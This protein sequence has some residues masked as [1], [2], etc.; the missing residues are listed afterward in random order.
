V[1][2]EKYRNGVKKLNE[3]NLGDIPHT[4][5]NSVRF[6][7]S[8]LEKN[9]SLVLG[10]AIYDLSAGTGYIANEFYEAGGVVKAFDLFPEQNNYPQIKCEKINLQENFPIADEQADFV[11]LSETFEHLPNQFH[12]FKEAARILKPSGILILTTPNPS[13]LRGR[14]SQFLME[15]EHYSYP[16]ADETNAYANWPGTTNKYFAKIFM[17]G[18]LRI[19]L[20]AALNG[21]AIKEIHKTPYSSTSILLLVFYP[22]I[23]FFSRKNLKWQ[24]K[25]SPE[26][27][28]IYRSIFAISTSLKIL[29]SKHL[30]VEFTKLGAS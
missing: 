15:S 8:Y 25:K 17:S 6:F 22:F 28:H 23:Y 2:G 14:F 9:K 7:L 30:V 24:L 5:E 16:L 29:L 12:F 1:R 13:S 10:K 19:R 11:I 20:L 27:E 21:L 18:I 26:N 4:R 3:M